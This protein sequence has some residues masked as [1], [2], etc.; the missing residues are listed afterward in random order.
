MKP[1]EEAAAQGWMT[2]S[3]AARELGISVS[4]CK[5]LAESGKLVMQK[6]VLGRLIDPK[7]VAKMKAEREP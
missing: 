3:Q 7:S 2:P 6:T 1:I 5:K 4:W